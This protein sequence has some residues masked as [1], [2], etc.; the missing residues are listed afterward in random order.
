M[1]EPHD[2]LVPVPLITPAFRYSL[3]ALVLG[4]QFFSR[5]EFFEGLLNQ[6]L[7]ADIF[8]GRN[9]ATKPADPLLVL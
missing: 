3:D 9:L 7:C 1:V 8:D 2:L 5:S 6:I 4:L